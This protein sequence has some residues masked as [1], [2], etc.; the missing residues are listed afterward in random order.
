MPKIKLN[1]MFAEVSG[2]MGGLVFKKSKRGEAIVASRPRKSSAAPSEAQKAQRQRFADAVAYAHHALKDEELAAVYRL[3][4]MEKGL[5]AFNAAVTDFLNKP[6]IQGIDLS[7]YGG[8]PGQAI[9][10]WT[11]DDT[12]VVSARV[13]VMDSDGRTLESG[14]AVESESGTGAW[15]YTATGSIPPGTRVEVWVVATDRPGNTAVLT[16]PRTI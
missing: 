4:G 16:E 12:A 15:V 14:D 8:Q 9:S 3:A 13:T 5:T 11:K 10:F 1:P 2:T 6:S 7:D